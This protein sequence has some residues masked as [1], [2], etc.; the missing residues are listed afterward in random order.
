[1]FRKDNTAMLHSKKSYQPRNQNLNES[2]QLHSFN[3]QENIR[4]GKTNYQ[5]DILDEKMEEKLKIQIWKKA[6]L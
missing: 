2:Q 5:K 3:Y 6:N 4:N 1:M